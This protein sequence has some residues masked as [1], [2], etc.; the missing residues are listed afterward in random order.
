MSW[1][2]QELSNPIQYTYQIE[3]G[4]CAFLLCLRH[5]LCNRLKIYIY[6]FHSLLYVFHW[7]SIIFCIKFKLLYMARR[8][9]V[10]HTSLTSLASGPIAHTSVTLSYL[11][12]SESAILSAFSMPLHMLFHLPRMPIPLILIPLANSWTIL[13]T[14][15]GG[16]L[17]RKSL[18]LCLLPLHQI[19]RVITFGLSWPLLYPLLRHNHLVDDM[20]E[21]GMHCSKAKCRAQ[22]SG[23]PRP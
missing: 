1:Q 2:S 17:F 18:L 10:I 9:F 16:C 8:S 14:R 21:G 23:H 15:S 4:V 6:S 5:S 11:Q 13:Q 12:C 20:H 19:G 7:L 3:S 22:I